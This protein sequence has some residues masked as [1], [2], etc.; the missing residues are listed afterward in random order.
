M[1]TTGYPAST[2]D[3]IAVPYSFAAQAWIYSLGIAPPVILSTNSNPCPPVCRLHFY[4]H[5]GELSLTAGLFHVPIMFLDRL[6][7]SFAV[8]HLRCSH[9]SV[10]LKF[11]QE[12]YPLLFQD[13]VHPFRRGWSGPF[14]GLHGPS[15][16]DLLVTV[17]PTLRKAC[18]R[19]PEIWIPRPPR[20]RAPE[21]PLIPAAADDLS[22]A[23]VS[24]VFVCFNPTAAIISPAK[25]SF[26]SSL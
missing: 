19:H 1:S 7:D 20:S 22:S 16:R 12:A 15:K 25:A 13:E 9:P 23:R 10:H 2:P 21:T 24:P 8:C 4:D 5:F 26:T 14:R 11:S 3:S 6:G 17:W 18:P